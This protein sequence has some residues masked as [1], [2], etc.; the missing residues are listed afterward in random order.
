MTK[1]VVILGF[2][3][4]FAAGLVIGSRRA[5]LGAP[6]GAAGGVPINAASGES[7]ASDSASVGVATAPSERRGPGGWL[8]AE[9]ALTP[10]QRQELDTIWSEM[11]RRGRGENEE[12][13][14]EHRRDRDAAIA[15]LVPPARLGEYDRIINAYQERVADLERESREAY[16]AAVEQTKEILTPE[17][18]TRYDELLRRHRWGPGSSRDRRSSRPS[19]TRETSQ[20]GQIESSLSSHP[21][22]KGAS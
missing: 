8:S 12:R 1:F 18:R 10:D 13:R 5:P 6:A 20:P 9:L 14:R 21:F 3:L 11:V 15:D 17:Q 22:S 4:S 19:E 2:A 7:A 16:E